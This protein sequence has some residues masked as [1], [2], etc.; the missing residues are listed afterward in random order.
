VLVTVSDARIPANGTGGIVGGYAAIVKSAT[1]YSA[2]GAPMA[3][4]SWSATSYRYGMNGQEHDQEFGAGTYTAEFWEYD[5]RTARRWNVDPVVKPWLSLYATFD[6]N[7]I[8]IADPNGDTGEETTAEDGCCDSDSQGGAC[9]G[10]ENSSCLTS[11][12]CSDTPSPTEEKT[13]VSQQTW[14]DEVTTHSFRYDDE[15]H[16][17]GNDIIHTNITSSTQR[18]Y[19]DGSVEWVT[20]YETYSA[21]IDRFGQSS[22]V[23]YTYWSSEGG[24]DG[25]SS[26]FSYENY[27]VDGTP[28]TF[29]ALYSAALS[30]KNDPKHYQ[31][32]FIQHIANQNKEENQKVSWITFGVKTVGKI[33]T[34]TPF[35]KTPAGAVITYAC[36]YIAKGT[37]MA[38]K[39]L[40]SEDPE[41]IQIQLSKS[42]V[43][44]F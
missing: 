15:G 33:V 3:G 14:K 8:R 27:P 42:T 5:S 29:N 20:T 41:Q 1:D 36:I 6:N 9:E 35:V 37:D 24:A 21:T 2:F 32:S 23:T 39:I 40:N 43:I 13:L 25:T 17:V 38:M 18:V 4:R 7:P 44:H 26:Q 34:Y 16:T 11:S 22:G 31:Q 12:D 19:S 10:T 30:F 28:E